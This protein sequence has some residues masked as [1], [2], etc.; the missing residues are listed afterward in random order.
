MRFALGF[1]V[2]C[3]IVWIGIPTFFILVGLFNLFSHMS[4]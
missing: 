4:P 2:F 1:I 3:L